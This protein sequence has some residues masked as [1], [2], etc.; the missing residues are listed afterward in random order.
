MRWLSAVTD[1]KDFARSREIDRSSRFSTNSRSLAKKKLLS[2]D[3]SKIS[4]ARFF[5]T[6]KTFLIIDQFLLPTFIFLEQYPFKYDPFVFYE[7]VKG[8]TNFDG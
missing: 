4:S 6:F 1:S 5:S 7:Q 2:N 8:E 3:T